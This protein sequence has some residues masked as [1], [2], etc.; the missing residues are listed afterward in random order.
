[1]HPG[2][3]KDRGEKAGSLKGLVSR[4]TYHQEGY[5]YGAGQI[6]VPRESLVGVLLS[7]KTVLLTSNSGAVGRLNCPW[8]EVWGGEGMLLE[9]KSRKSI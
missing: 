4:L 9:R 2:P 1:M 3:D 5:V 8:P 6:D 7:D